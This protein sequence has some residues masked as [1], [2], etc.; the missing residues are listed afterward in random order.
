MIDAIVIYILFASDTELILIM[1]ILT[2]IILL[3]LIRSIKATKHLTY[4]IR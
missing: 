2:L 4:T 3:V 1:V